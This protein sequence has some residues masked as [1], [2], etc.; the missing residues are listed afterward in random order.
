MAVNTFGAIDVGSDE[1]TLTIAECS[2]KKGIRI[3]DQVTHRINLGTDTFQTGKISYRHVAE[4]KR[5]LAEYRR[6]MDN[7]GV[8]DYK[9]YGTSAIRE[10]VNRTVVLSEIEQQTGIHIDTL[11]NSEQRFLDYKSIAAKGEGFARIIEKGTAIVD[12]GGSSIQ[13]SLFDKDRLVTT[14]NMKLGVLRLHDQMH[15]IDA[16][17]NRRDYIIEELVN[18][19]LRVFTN[20]YLQ[21]GRI[22]NIII[23][24]DYISPVVQKREISGKET[25]GYI[26]SAE[27]LAFMDMA[28]GMNPQDLAARLGIPDDNIPLFYLSGV[29]IRCIVRA[30]GTELLWAPGVTLCDGM[31]YEYAEAHRFIPPTHDFEEDII[32]CAENIARRY[33]GLRERREAMQNIAL[34]IFDS[35]TKYHGLGRR[36][37][38]LLRIAAILHDCGKYISMTG[39]A[40]CGYNIILSTEIIGLSHVEREIV[41]NVV[42]FNHTSFIYY[43]DPNLVTD[44]DSRA[45]LVIAKLTAIL[46]IANGLDRS[47]TQ[48]FNDVRIRVADDRMNILVGSDQDLTME[49]GLFDRRADF[50]EEIFGI[51]PVIRQSKGKV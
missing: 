4:L 25:P 26:G 47:H 5:L 12:I 48:K 6:I 14:Q 43:S 10:M 18:S 23:V 36:E 42:R 24:D 21:D 2:V 35:T 38:L 1:I 33:M 39:A 9:A 51:R 40:E 44:L 34:K 41:A 22:P 29:L 30:F 20:L 46:R 45:Y 49:K 50:F 3:I 31:I 19:Q 32:A 27:F 37:R 15:N 16:G 7:Y 17:A 13:I 28:H 11:S 8:T